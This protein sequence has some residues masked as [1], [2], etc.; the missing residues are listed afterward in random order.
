VPNDGQN[1]DSESED[2]PPMTLNTQEVIEQA[3]L[4]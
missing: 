3:D 4:H 2:A 1:P